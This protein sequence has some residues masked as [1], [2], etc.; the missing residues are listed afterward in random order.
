MGLEVASERQR[1]H[2]IAD[3]HREFLVNRAFEAFA[4]GHG[5]ELGPDLGDDVLEGVDLVGEVA[6]DERGDVQGPRGLAVG[7]ECPDVVLDC[8]EEGW[9]GSVEAA[10][11]A[12]EP[13]RALAAAGLDVGWFGA[14][15]E[16]HGDRAGFVGGRRRCRRGLA[17][18]VDD[19]F[20]HRLHRAAAPFDGDFEVA[21]GGIG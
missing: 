9:V 16:R 17:V 11:G 20:A 18:A 6:H 12:L 1:V 7:F 13:D 10:A 8:G 21:Q 19:V 2:A 14:V 5:G 3:E 4:I 15:A